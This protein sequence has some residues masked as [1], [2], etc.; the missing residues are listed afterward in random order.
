MLFCN[1]SLRRGGGQ[2]CEPLKREVPPFLGLGQLARVG[3]GEA[4]QLHDVGG[5]GGWRESG[6]RVEL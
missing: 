3:D 4:R 1:R 2:D 6:L 5:R